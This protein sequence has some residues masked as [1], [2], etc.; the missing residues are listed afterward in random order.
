MCEAKVSRR[1]EQR[2]LVSLRVSSIEPD[3]ELPDFL[4]PRQEAQQ[5][6]PFP[7]KD[8]TVL[9]RQGLERLRSSP[10][11]VARDRVRGFV[12]DPETGSLRDVE[13]PA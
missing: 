4:R 11:L 9:L 3:L 10:E 2:K 6:L 5:P 7:G 13:G 1:P 12:F 8:I